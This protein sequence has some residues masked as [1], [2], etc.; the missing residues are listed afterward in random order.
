MANITQVKFSFNNESDADILKKLFEVPNKQGYVKSLI[1]ADIGSTA[2]SNKKG[3]AAEDLTGQKFGTWTVIER[4]DNTPR[5]N[6]IPTWLCICDCG[7]TGYVN[8]NSLKRGLS[9]GCREC[10]YKRIKEVKSKKHEVFADPERQ[11]NGKK[12]KAYKTWLAIKNRCYN[13]K[14]KSFENY[15][16]RGIKLCEE[17][18]NDYH[19]FYIYVSSLPN[20][21]LHSYTIDRIDNDKGY[22]P[23]NVRWASPKQQANNRRTSNNEQLKTQN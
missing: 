11:V 19:K 13:P 21:N 3:P 22:E 5:N 4:A 9:K 23:G 20:Y 1:R 10:W 7:A 8:T 15:G 18:Y 16:G 12:T 17:W 14:H 6:R 2:M